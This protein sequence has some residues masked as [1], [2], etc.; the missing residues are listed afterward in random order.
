MKQEELPAW[1]PWRVKRLQSMPGGDATMLSSQLQ[2]SKEKQQST[3]IHL[4]HRK[5][6]RGGREDRPRNPDEVFTA[7]PLPYHTLSSHKV[8]NIQ[9]WKQT[10][11]YR[12]H[13]TADAKK[14]QSLEGP[15]RSTHD[16]C[17]G[18]MLPLS[19][20]NRRDILGEI[21]TMRHLWLGELSLSTGLS[22]HTTPELKY[23][24]C[25]FFQIWS[26]IK[27]F[28]KSESEQ[29]AKVIFCYSFELCRP[30]WVMNLSPSLE[31]YCRNIH[32]RTR[33]FWATWGKKKNKQA[34]FSFAANNCRSIPS[35]YMAGWWDEEVKIGPLKEQRSSVLN[36]KPNLCSVTNPYL[37]ISIDHSALKFEQFLKK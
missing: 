21:W 14:A 10:N 23:L 29:P 1:M 30:V 28:R 24:C 4:L 17:C 32:L 25:F 34:V 6:E 19:V 36:R 15:S 16:V 35:W 26:Q 2:M 37:K 31:R 8:L 7:A 27:Y 3:L 20:G 12:L 22:Q 5:T 11:L 9:T 33:L 13:S 18:V